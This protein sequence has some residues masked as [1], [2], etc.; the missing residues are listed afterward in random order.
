MVASY[1]IF[2]F[3]R[4]ISGVR[5]GWAKIHWTSNRGLAGEVGAEA[6]SRKK[7]ELLQGGG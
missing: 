5:R 2:F 1:H 3:S 4:S 7:E 6:E